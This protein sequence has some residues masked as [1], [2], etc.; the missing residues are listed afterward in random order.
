MR[1]RG[2]EVKRW[3]IGKWG[4]KGMGRRVGKVRGLVVVEWVGR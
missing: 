4:D 1:E 2:G 3:K